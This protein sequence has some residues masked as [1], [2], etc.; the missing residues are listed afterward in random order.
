MFSLS[1]NPLDHV[2]MHVG[3]PMITASIAKSK[4]LMVDP[5]LMQNRR[6]QIVNAHRIL[7]GIGSKLIGMPISHPR[8][9]PS[10]RQED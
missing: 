4:L 1:Q 2:S 3:E 9:K 8:L 10:P 7:N 6:M 5:H